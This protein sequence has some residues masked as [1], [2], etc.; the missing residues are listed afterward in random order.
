MKINKVTILVKKAT[1]EFDKMA[2]PFFAEYD[3]SVA[4]FRIIKFL[5]AQPSKSTRIVD[6]EKQYSITHPTAL[7]LVDQLEKKGYVKRIPNPNDKRGKLVSLTN[8]ANSMKKELEKIGYNIEQQFTKNL[9]V[10]EC[11][12][13]ARLLNK[14]LGM[15]E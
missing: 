4:Q 15:E 1:I 8:K 6:L 9:T 11:E 7:G 12:Q 10:Q 14:L 5:Y 3:L 2:N 13:L